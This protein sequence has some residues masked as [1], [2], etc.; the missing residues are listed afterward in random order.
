MNPFYK[1]SGRTPCLSGKIESYHYPQFQSGRP[2]LEK[3]GQCRWRQ[4]EHGLCH[5]IPARK[6]RYRICF[7]AIQDARAAGRPRIR[8]SQ[9]KESGCTGV[10]D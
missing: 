1:R 3:A 6:P 9:K 4:P 10:Y 7:D 5:I 2:G 8:D